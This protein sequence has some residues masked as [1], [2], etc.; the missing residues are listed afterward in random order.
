M[1]ILNP[2]ESSYLES[3]IFIHLFFFKDQAQSLGSSFFCQAFGLALAHEICW[4]G[5]RLGL[6][7]GQTSEMGLG[8]AQNKY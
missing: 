4:V 8:S 2:S 6:A 5:L 3:Y 7:G 1:F